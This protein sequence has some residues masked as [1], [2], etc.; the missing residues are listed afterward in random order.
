MRIVNS[1]EEVGSLSMMCALWDTQL[2]LFSFLFTKA[3]SIGL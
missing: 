1:G 2:Q 3:D